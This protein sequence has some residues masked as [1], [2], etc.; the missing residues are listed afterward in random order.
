MLEAAESA[1]RLVGI[2]FHFNR[3]ERTPNTVDSHRLLRLGEDQDQRANLLDSIFE[4]YF[5][6]GQD[7][8][9]REVLVDIAGRNG[10][11]AA[12]VRRS[13]AG[14]TDLAEVSAE[15]NRAHTIGMSGVPGFIF[16][17][18]FAIAGAQEPAI[19]LRMLDLSLE[20]QVPQPVTDTG[21][22]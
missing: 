5:V 20:S 13:L 12:A 9:D 15:N 22:V 4:A 3:I 14:A 6:N 11:D 17:G 21:P 1:G 19:F 2:P 18:R 7:I 10:L 16:N 8:G